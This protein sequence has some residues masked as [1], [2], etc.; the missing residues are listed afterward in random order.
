MKE[1][2]EN[3]ATPTVAIVA[4]L[5]NASESKP[6]KMLGSGGRIRS[7]PRT[8]TPTSPRH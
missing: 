4:K 7:S 8:Y 5:T 2:I 3:D 6:N 1:H